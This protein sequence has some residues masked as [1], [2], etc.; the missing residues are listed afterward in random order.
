MRMVVNATKK[1]VPMVIL[2]GSYFE[3]LPVIIKMT[4]PTPGQEIV[5]TIVA[6]FL[7]VIKEVRKQLDG[8]S[9]PLWEGSTTV[10]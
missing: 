4:Y 9:L 3:I 2:A 6:A 5:D 10:Q 8:I 1:V 7:V